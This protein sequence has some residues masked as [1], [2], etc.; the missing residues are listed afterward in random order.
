MLGEGACQC[1]R[2][3]IRCPG[4]PTGISLY[5]CL[6]C[7]RRTGSVVDV[8]AFFAKEQIT[9]VEGS[10]TQFRRGSNSGSDI[11]LQF[12]GIFGSTV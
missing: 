12:C 1:G 10:P 7:R 4:E 2:L 3:V 9:I 6:D 11:T 8:A 5:R